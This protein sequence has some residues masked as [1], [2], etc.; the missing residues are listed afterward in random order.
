[1]RWRVQLNDMHTSVLIG[2]E[3]Q[4]RIAPQKLIVS[5]SMEADYPARPA[6]VEECVDYRIIYH[7]VTQQ[8]PTRPHIALIETYATELLEA[9]F[10]HDA[11]I[12]EATVTIKK[13]DI[14]PDA[15][16]AIEARWTRQDFDRLRLAGR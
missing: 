4:E 16:P 5:A 7:L 15:T 11:R 12:A 10:T 13:T 6:S 1:M 8:W 2:V 14:F 9:I 3:P